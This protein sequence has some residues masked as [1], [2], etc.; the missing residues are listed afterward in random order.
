MHYGSVIKRDCMENRQHSQEAERQFQGGNLMRVCL[1]VRRQMHD[2][3]VW[4]GLSFG[5]WNPQALGTRCKL[6]P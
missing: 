2:G 4:V 6:D 3:F 5:W 1:S